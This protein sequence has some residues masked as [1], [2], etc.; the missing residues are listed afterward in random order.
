ME[1]LKQTHNSQHLIPSYTHWSRSIKKRHIFH[2]RYLNQRLRQLGM[3]S[4]YSTYQPSNRSVRR[5]PVIPF[6]L[7]LQKYPQ[8]CHLIRSSWYHSELPQ[9]EIIHVPVLCRRS[10]W[11]YAIHIHQIS[12]KIINH[13]KLQSINWKSCHQSIWN[14]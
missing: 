2:F 5:H 14:T 6:P 3:W 11:S 8:I 12:G 9:L 1:R 13:R 10:L 4:H 7:T